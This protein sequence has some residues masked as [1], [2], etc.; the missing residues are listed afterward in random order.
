M[1]IMSIFEQQQFIIPLFS[2]FSFIFFIIILFQKRTSSGGQKNSP[3]SPKGLPVIGNLL[4]LGKSPHRSLQ[5]LSRRYGDDELLLLHFGSL[6]VLLVSSAKVAREI[7]KNQDSIF[8][9]KP[10]LSVPDKLTYGSRDVAFT[11]YG[12]YW[13]KMRSICVHQLLSNKR[14]QS[15][16]HIRE[17]ET[18]NMIDKIRQLGSSSSSSINLTDLFSSLTNDVICMAL[19]GRKYDGEDRKKFKK[20]MKE[21]NDLLG[22][23]SIG[24]YIPWL[25]WI[26][27]VNGLYK[28]V[29]RAAKL[30]D[31]FLETVIREH[32]KDYGEKYD[33]ESYFVDRLLELQ[34]ESINSSSPISDDTVKALIVDMFIAGTD[35]TVTALEWAMAELIK[36]PRTMKTLQNQ[37]RKVAASN[38]K[39]DTINED[40][41]EKMP[42]LKAVIKESLRLHSPVPL[43][44]PRES[45]HDTKVMGYDISAGTRVVINTWA[46]GRDPKS[47]EDPENF[48]PERFLDSEVD[49]RGKDFELIPFGAGRRGCPGINFGVAVDELGLAKLVYHFDFELPNGEK[50]EDLDMSESGGITVHKKLPMLVV[51]TPYNNCVNS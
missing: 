23:A 9:N 39:K 17:Q 25:G 51:A 13:K 49:F 34:R 47:W 12:E 19:F 6:P 10:K 18:S 20:L 36:N 43:L 31:E 50:G 11:A 28:K 21:V 1:S 14:V 8:S 46:I 37:V 33:K 24:E 15:L 2:F 3:P 32:N 41:L 30:I 5:S 22:R 45:T 26:S 44:I 29:E 40:D 7:M 35:T 38:N 27:Y 16:R 48:F 4:M 42:Y